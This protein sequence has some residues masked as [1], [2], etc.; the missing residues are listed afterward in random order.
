MPRFIKETVLVNKKILITGVSS[1]IGRALTKELVMCGNSV[2][3]IARRKELLS[4]LKKEISNPK[5]YF[6]CAADLT[7]KESWKKVVI[8]LKRRKFVPDIIIFNAAILRCDVDT[9]IDLKVNRELFEV[10]YFS[11]MKGINHLMPIVKNNS[12]VIAIS[13]TSSQKGS[14][15]E[16]VGYA[17][18]KAALSISFE[19]LYQKFKRKLIFKI[20]FFGPV[21]TGM[22]P[23][24]KYSLLYLNEKQAVGEIIKAIKNDNIFYYRP[25]IVFFVLKLAKLVSQKLYF[26]ILDVIDQMHI[27]NQ[28]A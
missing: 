9:Q 25:K 2:F 8:S 10:N 12:Q 16:G 14:G 23:F 5:K 7:K 13:S 26:R 18:S 22:S 17:A 1:G 20:V 3:G 28:K 19:S 4:S 21:K 27:R 6:Y 11:I 24:K 15:I